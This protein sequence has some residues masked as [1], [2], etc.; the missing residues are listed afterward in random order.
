ARAAGAGIEQAQVI[1]NL[2]GGRDGGSWVAS[3]ILLF[4]GD[5]R[6]DAGNLVDIGLFNALEELP[7][8][9][10]ER[11]DIAPLTFGIDGI[12]GQ[13]RFSRSRY[14]REIGRASC[15]ERV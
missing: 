12:E 11:F 15:R 9:G 5:G 14:A 13:A 2:R 6:G 4:D 7:R 8:V 1:V 10:G 3:G